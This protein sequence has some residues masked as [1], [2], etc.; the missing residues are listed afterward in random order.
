MSKL[1][2][3]FT[4]SVFTTNACRTMQEQHEN[5]LLANHLLGK[6]YSL[7]F[8]IIIRGE[9]MCTGTSFGDTERLASLCNLTNR[10]YQLILTPTGWL[11]C[12]IIHHAHTLLRAIDLTTEGLQ[13][14]TLGPCRNFGQVSGQFIQI[15]HTGNQHLVCV[16]T[17]RSDDEL[18]ELYD[19][20]YHNVIENEVVEQVKNLGGTGNVSGIR[21]VAVQQQGNRSDCGVYSIAFTTCLIHGI[22]PQTIQFDDLVMRQHFFDCLRNN[23]P[24]LFPML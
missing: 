3:F 20:L 11:D 10:H 16:S 24:E 23:K 7:Q 19:S 18:V 4:Y 5:V 2:I 21:V 6:L 13:R 22:L 12:D 9:V 8:K 15:L 1:N 17:V 14:P